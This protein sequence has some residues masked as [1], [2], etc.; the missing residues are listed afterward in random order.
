MT[1]NP[2]DEKPYSEEDLR[3]AILRF[4]DAIKQQVFK[5]PAPSTVTAEVMN[6]C[7][8]LDR[9][10]HMVA[11][12]RTA[13]QPRDPFRHAVEQELVCAHLG[14]AG[15]NDDEETARKKLAELIDWHIAVATDPAVNGGFKLVPA[16]PAS[17]SEADG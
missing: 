1:T 10:A 5:L 14:V 12:L 11:A 13:S 8:S 9:L 2:N 17:A 7:I 15:E 4:S 16:T 3:D 6:L